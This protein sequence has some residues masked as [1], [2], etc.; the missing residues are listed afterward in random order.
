MLELVVI[1]EL[2]PDRYVSQ[3][4]DAHFDLPCNISY[5]WY[6]CKI[7]VTQASMIYTSMSMHQCLA[8]LFGIGPSFDM[9][10]IGNTVAHRTSA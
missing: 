9:T 4:E 3:S 5:S 7:E 6:E 8:R 2:L 1:A 10:A